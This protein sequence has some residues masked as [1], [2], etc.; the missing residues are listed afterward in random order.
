MSKVKKICKLQKNFKK[1]ETK[2][3]PEQS[4]DG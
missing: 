4:P 2:E 3:R 1:K